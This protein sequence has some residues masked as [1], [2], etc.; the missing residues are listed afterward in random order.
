MLETEETIGFVL[1]ISGIS[2][3][4]APD[5]ANGKFAQLGMVSGKR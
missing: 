3:G 4:V 2:N 5:Y 1:I